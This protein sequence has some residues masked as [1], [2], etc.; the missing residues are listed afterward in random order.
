MMGD[1]L[2][3]YCPR[4]AAPLSPGRPPGD[5]RDRLLCR[6]CGYVYYHNPN[7][8]VGAIP[9]LDGRIVLV[10]RAIEPGY[11]LWTFPGGY[12]E[13]DESVEEAAVRETREETGAEIRLERLLNV[14]SFPVSQVVLLVYVAQVLGGVIRPGEECLEVATFAPVEIPWRSLAFRSTEQALHDLLKY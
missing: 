7:V 5:R 13:I 6:A 9:F 10:R 1:S 11:G 12:V 4:C 8:A 14:Y 3:R 2:P